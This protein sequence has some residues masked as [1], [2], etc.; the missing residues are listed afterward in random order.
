MQNTMR[1]PHDILGV[2]PDADFETI[3][4]AYLTRTQTAHPDAGGS[5]EE[6]VRLHA[7]Y[8]AMVDRLARG[9]PSQD[10]Q[11]AEEHTGQG[12]EAKSFEDIKKEIWERHATQFAQQS[13]G[14][15]RREPRSATGLWREVILTS[16][17]A[18]AAA[19][20]LCYDVKSTERSLWSFA[21]AMTLAM[22]VYAGSLVALLLD[23][24]SSYRWTVIFIAMA[25][26]LIPL[27]TQPLRNL[28]PRPRPVISRDL[29]PK[30][31]PIQ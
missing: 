29:V 7:A 17:C 26:T 11:S 4:R 15:R 30:W 1:Q 27:A 23:G 28:E 9:T 21:F 18:A 3:R 20:Y 24:L 19:T 31:W 8:E 12:A 2:E 14:C 6:F 22:L 10:Q 13:T 25:A 5:R 16:L